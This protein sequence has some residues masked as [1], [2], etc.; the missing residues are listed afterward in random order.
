MRGTSYHV[1]GE[2]RRAPIERDTYDTR[3]AVPAAVA[4][5][6]TRSSTFARPPSRSFSLFSLAARAK[7]GAAGVSVGGVDAG[8]SVGVSDHSASD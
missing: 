3:S 4:A 1:I 6:P 5:R 7:F 8:A 2:A